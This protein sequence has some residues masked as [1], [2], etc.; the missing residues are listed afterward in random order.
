MRPALLLICILAALGLAWAVVVL[1]VL[2]GN[3]PETFKERR[4]R[5]RRFEERLGEAVRL[6]GGNLT[7]AGVEFIEQNGGGAGVRLRRAGVTPP[8]HHE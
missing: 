2:L 6:G 3:G 1:V 4:R 7:S 5:K 8:P